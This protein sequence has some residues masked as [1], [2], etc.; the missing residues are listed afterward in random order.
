[1]LRVIAESDSEN[2]RKAAGLFDH[3][4]AAKSGLQLG[5]KTP[6]YAER[7]NPATQISALIVFI[8]MYLQPF[9]YL[10]RMPDLF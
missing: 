3:W 2:R 7:R 5:G 4:G 1:L 6:L 8:W 9:A 10:S